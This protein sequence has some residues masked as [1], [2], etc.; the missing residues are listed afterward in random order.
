MTPGYER[1]TGSSSG[2]TPE[3]ERPEPGSGRA[4]SGQSS[5]AE[6]VPRLPGG[7]HARRW[8]SSLTGASAP[9]W[10]SGPELAVQLGRRLVQ[11]TRVGTGGQIPPPGIAD[12]A[13]D[14]GAL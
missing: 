9:V 2:K 3:I 7:R 14:V 4:L 1:P 5:A 6:P 12:H 10:P 8:P 13:R 11:R